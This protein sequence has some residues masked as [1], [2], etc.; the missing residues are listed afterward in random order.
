MSSGTLPPGLTL[1]TSGHV[2]GKPTSKGSH[3]FTVAVTDA[4]HLSRAKVLSIN[5]T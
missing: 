4:N 1:S 2:R 5:V 3:S